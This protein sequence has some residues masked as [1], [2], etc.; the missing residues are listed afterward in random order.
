[1]VGPGQS[2]DGYQVPAGV[3]DIWQHVRSD[4]VPISAVL[5]PD[6]GTYYLNHGLTSECIAF[7]FRVVNPAAGF[8]MV[9][10][11]WNDS[12]NGNEE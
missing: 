1:M 2:G 11:L 3:L 9:P 4:G 7:E 5:I 12:E 6:T 8:K 10:L